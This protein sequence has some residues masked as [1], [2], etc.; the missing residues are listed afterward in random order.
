MR[1]LFLV[2]AVL[3]GLGVTVVSPFAGVLIWTWFSVMSPQ[4]ETYG[5]AQTLPL[6]FIVAAATALFWFFGRE[7]KI[8]PNDIITWTTFIFLVW[9]TFNSFFAVDPAWSWPY[10]DRT[11]KIFALGLFV[12]MSGHT[13]VRLQALVWV[14]V[15]SLFY[16]GV[17]GGLFTLISGGGFHVIG[18]EGTIIADNNQLALALLMALP[19]ANYLRSQ[20][21]KRWISLILLA[22][23]ALTVI[24][25]LGSYSRGGFI[26]LAILLVAAWLRVRNKLV[27]PIVAALLIV[28]MLFFMPDSFYE[29]LSSI[30]SYN[31]DTSFQ[32]RIIA[33]EV[34]FDYARD[35]FPFGAG[36]YAPQLGKVFNVYFPDELPHAAHSIYFQVLGEQGFV[37]LAI[38]LVI[39]AAAFWKC[40]RI[41][42]AC[43]VNPKLQ[44]A[45]ELAAMI[46]LSLLVFCVSGAALSMAYYDVFIICTAMLLPLSQLVS[47]RKASWR[48]GGAFARLEPTPAE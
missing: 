14:T 47:P 38:Y 7:R 17:K 40:G 33:W 24:S 21:E 1:D 32:G 22:S 42:R 30:G 4:A 3:A 35:H 46:Q 9:I 43:G 19:L 31:S 28:P 25:V 36:F 15:I 6:N 23:M 16:Y 37:G 12:A 5:F 13:K 18:P 45:K 34:A 26:G 11:W 44:W 41:I 29:R 8:P 39:I 20:T 48:A 27:Y 2:V 10:W